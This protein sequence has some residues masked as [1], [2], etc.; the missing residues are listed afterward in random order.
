MARH[1]S[2]SSPLPHSWHVPLHH[3]LRFPAAALLVIAG[4]AHIPITPEHLEEAPYIGIL[5][6]ALTVVCFALALMLL[7]QDTALVW[8]AVVVVTVAAVL[9]Y[10]VS[11]MTALPQIA[12]DV[13]NWTDPLGLVSITSEFLAAT[14]ATAALASGQA[15]RSAT[16]TSADSRAAKR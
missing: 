7:G 11:R 12:D 9:A 5:F 13:G 6:I 8:A 2:A 14:L 10:L 1:A 16:S 15:Q 3:P 4:I